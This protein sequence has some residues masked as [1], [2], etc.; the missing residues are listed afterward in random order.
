[1][2]IPGRIASVRSPESEL[3]YLDCRKDQH[4]KKIEQD[5]WKS[6]HKGLKTFNKIDPKRKWQKGP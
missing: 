3:R 6:I 5:K 2:P 1:M 4:A